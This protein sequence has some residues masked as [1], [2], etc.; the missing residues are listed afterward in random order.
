MSTERLTLKERF[1]NWLYAIPAVA[2]FW[3][4]Q[5]AARTADVVDVSGAIPFT[6]LTKPLARCRVALIT[7]GGIHLPEQSA[8]DMTNPD[9]DAGYRVIPGDADL[10][11]LTITHKYYDHRDADADRNII[12]PL[13]HLRDLARQAVIGSVAPRHFGFMGH[14]DGDLI[15][16]LNQQ[17]APAVVAMLRKDQVDCVLLTPA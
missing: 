8:F 5:S 3:A 12:F 6:P 1:F 11:Q 2:Q 4:K 13:D 10:T 9:G 14:I 7:T 17:S 16:I 15:A